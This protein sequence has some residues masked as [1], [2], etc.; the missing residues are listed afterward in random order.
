MDDRWTDED[1]QPTRFRTSEEMQ[2]VY[3]EHARFLFRQAVTFT[4][5]QLDQESVSIE[6]R[7]KFLGLDMIAERPH[8][9][10]LR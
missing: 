8:G 1:P 2:Q 5:A 6:L 7:R 10:P 4:R 9:L 3:R